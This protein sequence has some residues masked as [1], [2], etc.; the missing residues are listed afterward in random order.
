METK[1]IV[2]MSALLLTS[3]GGFVVPGGRLGVVLEP[4]TLAGAYADSGESSSSE[5]TGDGA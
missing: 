2:R 4:P 1:K 3:A 5:G